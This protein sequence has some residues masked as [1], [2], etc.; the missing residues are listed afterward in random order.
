[1]EQADAAL[2]LWYG[3]AQNP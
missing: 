3:L 2:R 1:M